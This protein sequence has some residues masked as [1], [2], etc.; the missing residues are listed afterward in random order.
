MRSTGHGDVIKMYTKNLTFISI[1]YTA[2]M[3]LKI[4]HIRFAYVL[5]LAEFCCIF[6]IVC[7]CSEVTADLHLHVYF[8]LSGGTN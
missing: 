4:I 2:V 5:V 8:S 1:V 7:V 6:C 3:Q